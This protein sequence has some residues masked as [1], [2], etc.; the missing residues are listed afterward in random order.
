M[1]RNFWNALRSGLP[2]HKFRRQHPVG[3]HIVDFACPA[4]KLAIEL[5]GGQH[6]AQ[7]EMD[8]DRSAELAERGYGVIRSWNNEVVED[9][10]GVLATLLDALEASP[11]HPE[12][13]RPRAE[14]G[15]LPRSLPQ[16]PLSALGGEGRGEVATK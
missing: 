5:D 2:S 3:R 13:L 7:F 10:D 11:P 14:R 4:L 6:A 9:L 1:E 8:A 16:R 12:P 15:I